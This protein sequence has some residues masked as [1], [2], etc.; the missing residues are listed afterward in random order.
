MQ[1]WW[2]GDGRGLCRDTK[3]A[4]ARNNSISGSGGGGGGRH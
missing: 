1:G 2:D 3:R 4:S